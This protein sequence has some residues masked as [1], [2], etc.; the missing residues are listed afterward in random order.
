MEQTAALSILDREE[1]QKS[2]RLHF[3]SQIDFL[4]DLVD[5][6]THLVADTIGPGDPNDVAKLVVCGAFLKHM[7]GMIDAAAV[8]LESGH[9]A[10]PPLAGSIRLRSLP[11]H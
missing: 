1:A 9:S 3:G 7:V 6:G 5:Y 4:N 11:L 2:A 8:L 10:P